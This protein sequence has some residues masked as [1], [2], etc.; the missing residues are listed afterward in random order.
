MLLIH[1]IINAWCFA[2]LN[3]LNTGDNIDASYQALINPPVIVVSSSIVLP[4]QEIISLIRQVDL[5]NK[6]GM[7]I[8]GGEA[9][10]EFTDRQQ[11]YWPL[12]FEDLTCPTAWIEGDATVVASSQ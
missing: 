10:V 9:A 7:V 5:P 11:D 4:L 6:Q 8:P 12:A 3:D 1:C 2:I